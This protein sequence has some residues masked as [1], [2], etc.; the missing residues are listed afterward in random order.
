[1][2]I[3]LI[4]HPALHI[5]PHLPSDFAVFLEWQRRSIRLAPAE[6]S[7]NSRLDCA[8]LAYN[9]VRSWP[10]IRSAAVN[11]GKSDM[12]LTYRKLDPSGARGGMFA[13]SPY[14]QRQIRS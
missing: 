9:P 10:E 6:V 14:P 7:T 5:Y 13:C 12:A 2:I 4:V 11:G 1:M 3:R 8:N